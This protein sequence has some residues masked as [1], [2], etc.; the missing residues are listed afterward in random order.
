MSDMLI[1]TLANVHGTI[2]MRGRE[3]VER[4]ERYNQYFCLLAEHLEYDESQWETD[5]YA[6]SENWGFHAEEVGEYLASLQDL[7]L[8]T[9]SSTDNGR[10]IVRLTSDAPK[11]AAMCI[12]LDL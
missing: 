9:V 1:I 7:G 6:T 12:L 11:R 2:G 10:V 8:I 3:G 5:I 4:R